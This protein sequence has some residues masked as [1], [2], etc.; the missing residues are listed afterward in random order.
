[1]TMKKFT[2]ILF[3]MAITAFGSVQ[4]QTKIGYTN[5][6]LILAYMPETK[7]MEKTLADLEKR[8]GEQL[9]VKQKYYQQ[10][11]LEFVEAQQSGQYTESQMQVAATELGKLEKEVQEAVQLAQQQLLK[12][13]M[14][15]LNPIQAKMQKAIDDVAKEGG[16]T[17]VLNN[18][19]GSGIPSIL[20]GEDST[21]LTEA[22]AKKLGI[23]TEE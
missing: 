2:W 7:A 18:A 13:R 3:L 17:Y 15:M 8:I 22:I 19:M 23:N 14:E 9:E 16:F 10:K 4:A 20:F 11:T 6:E 21:D 12:K 5:V 1:M